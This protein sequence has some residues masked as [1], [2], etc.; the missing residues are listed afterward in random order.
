MLQVLLAV[1]GEERQGHWARN[2]FLHSPVLHHAAVCGIL[3]T[4]SVLLAAG[5]DE[6][7]V[8]LKGETASEAICSPYDG[9]LKGPAEKAAAVRMLAQGPAFRTRS[10]VWPVTGVDEDGDVDGVDLDAS[11]SSSGAQHSALDVRILRPASRKC[12]V[13]LMGG[14]NDWRLPTRQEKKRF[15]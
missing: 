14:N 1:E 7:V 5:A 12:F 8:N 4:I 13:R 10:W 9:R 2:W 11:S 6:T 15:L 3:A